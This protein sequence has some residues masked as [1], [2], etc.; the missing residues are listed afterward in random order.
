MRYSIALTAL[1][2]LSAT[3][4]TQAEKFN[5]LVIMADDCTFRDLPMYGGENAFTPNLMQFA[6]Q[7]LTF[8]NAYLTSAMCQPCR[9]ELYTGQFPLRNG[10]AWNHSASR[11]DA[12]S[13]PQRL[14]T[15]G[16]RTGIA[17]KVHVKPDSVFPFENV[18]GFD[19]NC[20]RNPT[21]QHETTA[22]REFM[23]RDADQPFCLVV[24]LTEPHIPWVMGDA[25]R[26]PKQKLKL[27]PNIADTPRTREDYS[28]YLAEITYMDGQVGEILDVLEKTGQADNT[29]VLFTS[30][31]G[32]QFPGCKW[33]NWDTGVH[34]GLIARWPG[35]IKAGTRTDAIVHYADVLPTILTLA[36]AAEE[37][38]AELDGKS[39]ADVLLGKSATHRD[40]A[41]G[42]H[43]NVPEGPSYP[44]RSITNGKYRYIRN[45]SP[46]EIY[47]ER[48]LMGGGNLNNPYWATW[49]QTAAD[50]PHTYKL[51]HRY[52]MRPAEQ[53]YL[54]SND[55]YEMTNLIDSPEHTAV[56]DDLRTHLDAWMKSQGD[57]GAAEDTWD[58][59]KA[60]RNGEH[61]YVA[62]KVEE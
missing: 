37:N 33:T 32:C 22:I 23:G 3:S 10:C 2:C 62:P 24:A 61:L 28:H 15:S 19:P 54:T 21:L 1:L 56:L 9:A 13:L 31:Q 14:K 7:G 30:E 42:M 35:H 39:F 46:N 6:S 48:H 60:A 34:T 44:I 57:P 38:F 53:L 45:L 47:I 51:V 16:Y 41:F 52:M 4:I 40:Y 5:V 43:N 27:P 59:L 12:I 49:M 55:P 36:N 11:P 20:V 25:S 8:N 17:G 58:A 50:N 26:Y 18:P 29:L